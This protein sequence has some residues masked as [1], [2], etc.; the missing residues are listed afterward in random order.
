LD[1]V[2]YK[3]SVRILYI[4]VNGI[5]TGLHKNYD[6]CSKGLG[7]ALRRMPLRMK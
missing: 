7:L 3:W 4:D 2:A 5:L 6:R 1:A